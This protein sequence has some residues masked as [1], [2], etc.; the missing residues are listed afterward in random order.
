[1]AHAEGT[2]PIATNRRARHDYAVLER[3]EA[4]VE[5]RGTEVKSL[6]QGQASLAGSFCRIENGQVFA[7]G[8]SIPPYD[9]GNRFNH[10]ADRPKRLLLHRGQIDKLA[11]QTEQ[12]GFVLI[13]L[14]AYFRRN[15]VKIDIGVCRGKRQE[16]KRET[17][18]RRD[19]DRDAARAM[20]QHS[21][22]G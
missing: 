8:F 11:V 7:H 16:D 2:K 20:A 3:L 1:M 10:P 4:G 6:R 12:K 5:L 18:K 19:A 22:R 15:I 17:L 21:R 9:F 14:S 13:P